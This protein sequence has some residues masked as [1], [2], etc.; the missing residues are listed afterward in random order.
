[1]RIIHR[2]TMLSYVFERS[3]LLLKMTPLRMKEKASSIN[4]NIPTFSH[5]RTLIV[6]VKIIHLTKFYCIN[7]K[8]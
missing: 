7:A 1:M 2:I 5:T 4:L 6:L 3:L 8:T